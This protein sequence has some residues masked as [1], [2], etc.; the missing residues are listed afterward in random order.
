MKTVKATEM[1]NKMG[2]YFQ[3][4]MAEPI[5]VQR[6][7]HPIAI[8]L[9]V[10]EYERLTRIEDAYWGEKTKAAEAEGFLSEK[11]TKEF[12]KASLNVKT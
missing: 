8:L 12:M 3:L 11:E 4:A 2:Q 1:K 6:N 5:S 10:N 7:G 9:S